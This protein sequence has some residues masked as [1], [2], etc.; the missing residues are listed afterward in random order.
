MRQKIDPAKGAAIFCLSNPPPF[1][2]C[3]N[4][5]SLEVSSLLYYIYRM[6]QKCKP[7]LLLQI[8]DKAG[9]DKIGKKQKLLT[10]YLEYL[11]LKYFSHGEVRVTIITPSNPDHRGSQLSLIFNIEAKFA[12]RKME[13]EGIVVSILKV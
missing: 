7:H 13:E 4:F 11:L 9:M 6:L 10:G 1:L 8:F 12:H 2:A 5:A 3:L